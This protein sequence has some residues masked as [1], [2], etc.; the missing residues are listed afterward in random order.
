MINSLRDFLDECEKIGE[1]SRVKVQ[2]DWDLELNHVADIS[3]QKGGPA[4]IFEN[5]KGC[6]HSCLIAALSK[7]NRCAIA[8]E[9]PVGMSRVE[10]AREWA[11]R[12]N[13]QGIPPKVLSSGPVQ[14]NVIEEKDVDLSTLPVPKLYPMDGG[15]YL[16]TTAALITREPGADWDNLGTYR[17]QILGR[18]SLGLNLQPGKHAR[19]ML[20]RYR[21]LGRKM[22]AAVCV[23]Q[24]PVLFLLASTGVP[25]GVSEYDAAGGIRGE[26]VEVIQ[27][28]LTGLQIPASAEYVL[29]GEIDPD[30]SAYRPEGPFGE[31]PG[32]YSASIAED[33]PKPCFNVKRMFHRDDPIFWTQSV[34]AIGAGKNTIPSIQISASIWAGL[35]NLRIPGIKAVYC[36]PEAGGRFMVV[37]AIEQK[38]YGHAVQ[39]G[40]AVVA[41]TTGN[42]RTKICIVV[43]DDIHPDNMDEVLWALA[44]RSDAARSVQVFKRTFGEELDPGVPIEQRDMNSKLFIDATIPF[45]WTRK[46]IQVQ[47]DPA[48]IEKVKKQWEKY[49]INLARKGGENEI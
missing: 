17:M 39:V 33:Y 4:L 2:V 1:L 21:K 14:D 15:R 30:P 6:K 47:M 26:A 43:D 44:T 38:Y 48:M 18:N 32:Y 40:H 8:L 22:P 12:V 16:G 35:D 9:M 36:P 37:V 19:L 7:P 49:D 46:P 5:V 41:T 11:V 34:G 23:G 28:E 3:D 29:E 13:R 25:W 24:L 31:Y 20:E 45:E 42:Y 10:M 27:G